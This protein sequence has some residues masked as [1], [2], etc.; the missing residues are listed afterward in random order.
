MYCTVLRSVHS[1]YPTILPSHIPTHI[2]HA[3]EC[4]WIV[5]AFAACNACVMQTK[6]DWYKTLRCMK[7]AQRSSRVL[8]LR[9]FSVRFYIYFYFYP[10]LLHA[11]AFARSSFIV[12]SEETRAVVI[13]IQFVKLW[14]KVCL[15]TILTKCCATRTWEEL[16]KAHQHRKRSGMMEEKRR[17]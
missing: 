5:A 13:H 15:Y 14:R 2:S 17:E 3:Y 16:T 9:A 7:M 8:V 1:S 6:R 4:C 12:L 10:S 11:Y